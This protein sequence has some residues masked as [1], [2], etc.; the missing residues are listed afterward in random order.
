MHKTIRPKEIIRLRQRRLAAVTLTLLLTGTATLGYWWYTTKD[1]AATDDAFVTGHQIT[2][3]AQTEGTIVEILAENTQQVRHGQ[4]LVRL[5]GVRAQLGLEQAQAELGETVRH[6]EKLTAGIETLRRRIESRQAALSQVSH[7]LQRYLSAYRDG[8]ASEQQV[9]NAKDKI[10]EL[11]AAIK[12]AEAEKSGIEAEVQ[13]VGIDRHPSVE[14][15]KSKLRQAF[16]EYRRS[17]IAAPASGFVAKRRA[18]IGDMVK[19]GTPLLTIVPLDDLWIE[20]NFLENQIADIRP[21]Q[22]A[23]IRIDAYGDQIV[24]HGRVQGINPGTGSSFALLPTDNATGNFIH[25]AER[26]PVR[27]GLNPQE[28]RKNP[29][30]P[31]LSTL[32]RIKISEAGDALLASHIDIAGEAYRTGIYKHELDDAEQLIQKI[33][34]SNRFD[35]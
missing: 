15:A 3:K 2:L 35:E 19:P 34:A 20:A 10:R 25:I 27:I 28:L 23:E 32:T 11:D 7:D 33:V 9:Q 29:L 24:Y 16:L 18:Q 26:V 13:G 5:D 17:N 1:W 6:I 21:G 22:S 30:Q 4:V 8:A 12:E 31:G 14:K